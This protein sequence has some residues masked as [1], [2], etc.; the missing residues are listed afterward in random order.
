MKVA[1][2]LFTISNIS[3]LVAVEIVVTFVK[4]IAFVELSLIVLICVPVKV[5]SDNFNVPVF[6]PECVPNCELLNVSV[7]PLATSNL[8]IILFI[9]EV[10]IFLSI[11]TSRV[12]VP[13]PFETVILL[14]SW[15]L[16]SETIT[17]LPVPAIVIFIVLPDKSVALIVAV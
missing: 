1:P 14:K 13:V 4:S 8:S 17:R 2:V 9:F 10:L 5:V 11:L 7:E 16:E 3:E 12:T 15:L 6:I